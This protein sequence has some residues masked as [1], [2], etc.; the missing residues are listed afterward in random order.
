M[1]PIV[2]VLVVLALATA[3][4]AAFLVS[5]YLTSLQPAPQ[6]ANQQ[7]PVGAT[8]VLVATK[9]LATGAVLTPDD[10]RWIK[11]PTESVDRE[12]MVVQGAAGAAAQVCGQQVT[13]PQQAFNDRIVR[14]PIM[15][16]EPMTCEMVIKQGDGSV[17]SA[18]IAPGM[19]AIT[20][21]VT[22][23]TGVAGLVLPGDK[24]DIVMNASVRDLSQL[25]GWKDVIVR[26]TSETIMKD[27]RVVAIN[28]K[29]SHDAKEGV[30]EPGN[31][32]TLEVTP[33][34]AERLLVAQQLGTLT[35]ALRSLAPGPD[36][37]D[38]TQTF[39]MDIRASRA[40]ASMVALG[41]G[42]DEGAM[43]ETTADAVK[44]AKERARNKAEVKINRGGAVQLQKFGQ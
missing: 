26:Y 35:L 13:D 19:R 10:T 42:E 20:I 27:V 23:A 17:A 29:L 15:S 5:R 8:D 33:K 40:L 7:A 38:K 1:R 21:N 30:A 37:K 39:T 22:Q 18:A 28:Q 14:R 6:A 9:N 44:L 16:G 12:R 2:L 25:E 24:V 41:L 3:A 32:A 31:L 4:I 34:Q 43:P 36:D 11:W